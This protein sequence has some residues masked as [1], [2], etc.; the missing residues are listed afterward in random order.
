ME[1]SDGIISSILGNTEFD[2]GVG[3]P[4]LNS[5]EFA[6]GG[7]KSLH[8]GC[9]VIERPID[10]SYL[11]GILCGKPFECLYSFFARE[12]K[13]LVKINPSIIC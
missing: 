11:F 8:I 1:F 10:A 5:T 6:N 7:G 2:H 12:N 4:T 3:S 9:Y 13:F